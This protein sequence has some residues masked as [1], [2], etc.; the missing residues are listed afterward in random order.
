MIPNFAIDENLKVEFLLPDPDLDIFI[1][2]VSTL[3]GTDVLGTVNSF[4]LG[5]SLLGGSNVLGTDN[6][7]SWQEV[8][9]SVSNADISVGG[10]IQDSIYFQPSPG[11]AS[12]TLQSFELDPTVNPYVRAGTK[13]RI[14]VESSEI[15][16]TLFQGFI[17]T[18]NVTYYPDGLNLIRI[19]AFD[20]YKRLVNSTF[21]TFEITSP[22]IYSFEILIRIAIESG[23]G[24]TP[25]ELPPPAFILVPGV[26]ET[27]VLVS[28]LINEAVQTSLAIVWIDQDTE[29][30]AITGRRSDI[31]LP[32]PEFTIGNNHP[33]DFY[34]YNPYHFCLSEINVFSDQDAFYNVLKLTLASDDTQVV[35]R[36]D[37]DS[38]D[39]YGESAVDVT[40]NVF[41]TLSMNAWADEVFKQKT[42][43]LV[44]QVT[45]PAL[46][47]LGTLTN[48]AVFTPGSR[49]NVSYA[50]GA[51]TIFGAYTII[52]VSHRIDV[53][54]WFTTF[55]VWKEA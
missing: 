31:E 48:A 36:K 1:L 28:S 52:K 29:T 22:A 54:N 45:T 39:F 3:G 38:I 50:K 26:S 13:I 30:L 33:S 15:D 6:G 19:Q 43:N 47:R 11:S 51:V 37:Q 8:G 14:R 35:I 17:D 44:N 10:E 53:D 46:D 25:F 16:R 55:D 40:L 49:I 32:T 7:L 21:E 2:G 23:L 27:N 24:T 4:I 18:I 34:G 41:D 20:A 12:L 5:V 42:E 9:C